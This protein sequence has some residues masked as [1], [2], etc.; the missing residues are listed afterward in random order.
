MG[1]IHVRKEG[2]DRTIGSVVVHRSVSDWVVVI[3]VVVVLP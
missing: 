2:D 1:S 3:V